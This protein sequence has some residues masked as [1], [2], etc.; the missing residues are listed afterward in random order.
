VLASVERFRAGDRLGRHEVH[1]RE[2][3]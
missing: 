1:D 3:R 2:V